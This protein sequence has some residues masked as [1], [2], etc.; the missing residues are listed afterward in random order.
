MTTTTAV[1]AGVPMDENR[2]ISQRLHLDLP[3]LFGLMVLSL[4]GLAKLMRMPRGYLLPV[5]LVFCVVGSYALSNRM[6]DLKRKDDFYGFSC[7]VLEFWLL[8][9]PYF[10]FFQPKLNQILLHHRLPLINL[11]PI[12]MN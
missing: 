11:Q 3:L 8:L 1:R 4:R 2:S 10:L 7:G 5:I 6:F 12:S 9:L